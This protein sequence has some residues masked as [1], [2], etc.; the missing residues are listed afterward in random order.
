VLLRLLT[1]QEAERQRI[2]REL[3]DQSG[4][5]LAALLLDV[6]LLEDALA[7]DP[8]PTPAA[9]E[10]LERVRRSAQE[11]ASALHAVTANLRP[12]PLATV[13]ICV[14]LTNYAEDWSL[15]T[16]VG[17]DFHSMGV[18]SQRLSPAVETTIYRVV[19]EA[20]TNVLRHATGATQ[21]NIVIERRADRWR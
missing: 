10:H 9:Q 1:A 8:P 18:L 14:S 4:Q 2:A 11:L 7:Q 6:K 15:R 20:L 16:G 12:A 21:V 3:H 13:G 17:A 19:V 5:Y